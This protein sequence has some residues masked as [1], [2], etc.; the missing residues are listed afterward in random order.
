MSV[1]R[2]RTL[3]V[4]RLSWQPNRLLRRPPTGCEIFPQSSRHG[5]KSSRIREPSQGSLGLPRARPSTTSTP[6]VGLPYFDHR[7]LVDFVVGN[8][9]HAHTPAAG[10]SPLTRQPR[11]SRGRRSPR[12]SRAAASETSVPLPPTSAAAPRPSHPAPPSP[13]RYLPTR[14]QRSEGRATP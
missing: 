6:R 8:E 4:Q 10:S 2:R 12:D 1:V 11:S 5:A 13:L 9:H 3:E 14:R 7:L